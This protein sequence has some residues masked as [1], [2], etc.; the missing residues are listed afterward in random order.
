LAKLIVDG[1]IKKEDAVFIK[2]KGWKGIINRQHDPFYLSEKEINLK[3]SL[4]ITSTTLKEKLVSPVFNDVETSFSNVREFEGVNGSNFSLEASLKNT[5][6]VEES[7][8]RRA[9]ITLLSKGGAIIIALSAKGCISEISLLTGRGFTS[10]KEHDLSAFGCDFNDFEK[11]VCKVADQ[12]LEIYLNDKLIFSEDQK[13]PVGDI[14]GIRIA[15]EGAGEIKAVKLS[16]LD[17]VV[18]QEHF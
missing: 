8:C 7:L 3:G 14:V 1:K 6:T 11:L 2:T 5:S 18:Y 15:F 17:K 12:K 13:T 9:S 4:G 10:G 16:A